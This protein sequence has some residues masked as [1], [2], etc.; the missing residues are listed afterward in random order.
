MLGLELVK[1]EME[2]YK[3]L[4]V[5]V[6]VMFGFICITISVV[7]YTISGIANNKV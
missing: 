7:H 4:L 1:L 2:S 5:V 3:L 6:L